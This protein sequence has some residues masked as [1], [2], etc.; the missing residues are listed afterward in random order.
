MIILI[1]M[2][3]AIPFLLY[4]NHKEWGLDL[5]SIAFSIFVGPIIG[6]FIG[7]MVMATGNFIL[8]TLPED[9][10]VIEICGDENLIALKDNFQ[11]NGTAFIFTSVVDENLKYSFLYETDMGIKSYSVNADNSYIKYINANETPHVQHW[12]EVSAN[13]LFNWLF[14]PGAS[15][16]TFYL[17]EGSVIENTYEVD[18]E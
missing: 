10:R 6:F 9:T 5:G 12:K 18:L 3:G 14:M 8:S 1:F 2:I 17:P 16:W 7:A 13:K 4:W 15:H 11:V